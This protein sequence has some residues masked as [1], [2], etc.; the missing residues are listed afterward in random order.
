MNIKMLLMF[1]I[2]TIFKKL[3]QNYNK[4]RDIEF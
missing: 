4:L 3:N 1:I 2:F